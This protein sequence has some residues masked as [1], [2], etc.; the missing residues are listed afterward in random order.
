MISLTASSTRSNSSW[1]NGFAGKIDGRGHL[2]QVERN[3]RCTELAIHH[4]GKQMLTRVLLHV[5]AATAP[6]DVPAHRGSGQ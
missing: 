3:R 6:V 1:R 4:R 5:V 2:A